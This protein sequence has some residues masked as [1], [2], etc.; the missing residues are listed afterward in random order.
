[1]YKIIATVKTKADIDS[2]LEKLWDW[3][4]KKIAF[5]NWGDEFSLSQELR[6]GPF[7]IIVSLKYRHF[8]IMHKENFDEIVNFRME[9]QYG[10]SYY[11]WVL[12]TPKENLDI[13]G[14][15]KP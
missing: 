3:S 13:W 7:H 6:K 1:M 9:D 15:T 5:P 10:T 12:E 8:L 11:R 14:I 4:D 2:A